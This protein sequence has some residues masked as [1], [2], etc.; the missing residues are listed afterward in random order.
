V[1]KV[2]GS[3]LCGKV[4]Y[5]ASAGPVFVAACHCRDCQKATGAAHSIN[6]AVPANALRV[7][8]QLKPF[9][10]TGGSGEAVA[11]MF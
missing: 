9:P 6:V 11:R 1:Q 4:R 5:R 3:C 10:T 7:E 2:E 8:G